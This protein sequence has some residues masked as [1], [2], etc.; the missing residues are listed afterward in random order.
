MR[1]LIAAL[2]CCFA[3]RSKLYSWDVVFRRGVEMQFDV[4]ALWIGRAV[5]MV[6]SI[7]AFI[8]VM[9]ILFVFVYLEVDSFWGCN[10]RMHFK[11]VA[12]MQ[13]YVVAF[14]CWV[15]ELVSSIL[16]FV[17]VDWNSFRWCDAFWCCGVVSVVVYSFWSS[18]VRMHFN[19]FWFLI[20]LRNVEWPKL[21]ALQNSQYLDS[22]L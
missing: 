21:V 7:A 19:V 5:A 1:F 2:R 22:H 10:V 16:V 3:M 6:S 15:D 14:L 13:S 12:L 4:V 8:V 17:V 18:H 9:W 11:I 20:R